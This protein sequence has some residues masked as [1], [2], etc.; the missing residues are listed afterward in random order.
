MCPYVEAFVAKIKTDGTG[1]VY[2]GYIGGSGYDIGRGIAVDA[3][4][5]AYV[6][7]Y[8]FSSEVTFPVSV[9]PDLTYN[10]SGDDFIGTW[11]GQG[12]YYRNSAN[13]SWMKMATPASQITAEDLDNDGPDNLVGIWPAQNGVWVKYSSTMSWERLS[14]TADWIACGKQPKL[15]PV[16]RLEKDHHV[17][18]LKF[19]T[20]KTIIHILLML[21]F[22]KGA[23]KI[24]KDQKLSPSF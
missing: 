19:L 11:T 6:T 16:K 18:N 1:F 5:N 21:W 12:V 17:P 13:D 3:L 22:G 10:G 9:G 14:S 23:E 20:I 24:S 2:C 7:G 15:I 4:G 8:T